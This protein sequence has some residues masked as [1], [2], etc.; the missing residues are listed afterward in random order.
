MDRAGRIGTIFSMDWVEPINKIN[1]PGEQKIKKAKPI[2]KE[3]KLSYYS[4]IKI[5]P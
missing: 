2:T 1:V 5:K 3:K 4:G